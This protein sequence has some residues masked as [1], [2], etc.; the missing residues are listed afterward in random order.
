MGSFVFSFPMN[1]AQIDLFVKKGPDIFQCQVLCKDHMIFLPLCH[2]Q[3]MK[4]E[5]I[6]LINYNRKQEE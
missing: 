4:Y 2:T 6:F 1:R 5:V 3:E